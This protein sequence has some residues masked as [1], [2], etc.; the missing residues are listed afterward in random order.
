MLDGCGQ[1]ADSKCNSEGE[2]LSGV[3]A[4]VSLNLQSSNALSERVQRQ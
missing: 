2:D 4:V 1:V 3:V